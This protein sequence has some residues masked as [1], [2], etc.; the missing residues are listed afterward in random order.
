MS[1]WVIFHLICKGRMLHSKCSKSL[2]N[3]RFWLILLERRSSLIN[4]GNMLFI[5]AVVKVLLEVHLHISLVLSFLISKVVWIKLNPNCIWRHHTLVFFTHWC[6]ILLYKSRWFIWN[7]V[8]FW[9]Q[10]KLWTWISLLI[11]RNHPS[12]TLRIN[13]HF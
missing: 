12:E 4:K 8:Y 11:E 9:T 1:H 2:I 3:L 10:R 13:S 5:T 7:I 6:R